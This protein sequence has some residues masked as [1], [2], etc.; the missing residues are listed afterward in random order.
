[1]KSKERTLKMKN[2]VSIMI[3]DLGLEELFDSIVA[4]IEKNENLTEN[5]WSIAL[6]D[7]NEMRKLNKEYRK[8]DKTT[9]V[10]SFAQCDIDQNLIID[11]N[12]LGEI[13]INYEQAKRQ[14]DNFKREL[15]Y[16]LLHGYLHLKSYVHETDEEEKK[17]NTELEKLISKVNI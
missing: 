9:D 2:N 4:Q 7:D 1:M 17:M 3:E 14:S 12:F 6:I 16:L 11:K 5:Q 13:F 15:V 10:L 8:K